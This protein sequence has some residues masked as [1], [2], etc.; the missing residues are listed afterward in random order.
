MGRSS[1]FSLEQIYR[2]QVTQTWSK[3]PEVFRYVNSLGTDAVSG[4]AYGYWGGGYNNSVSVSRMQRLVYSNDT[5]ALTQ[6]G[7]IS[8]ARYN[9]V[10]TGNL[11]YGYWAGGNHPAPKTSVIDRLDYANDST[12]TTPKGPLSRTATKMAAVATASYGY[13]ALMDLALH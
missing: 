4:P 1:V 13:F 7:S 8:S 5:A 12:A 11:S 10:G 2:K 3:I 6:K 9:P